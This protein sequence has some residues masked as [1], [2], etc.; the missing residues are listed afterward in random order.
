MYFF[1]PMEYFRGSEF[2]IRLD[3]FWKKFSWSHFG[4]QKFKDGPFEMLIQCTLLLVEQA[5]VVPDMTLGFTVRKHVC[6]RYNHLGFGAHGEGPTKSKIGVISGPTKMDLGPT[7]IKN[8]YYKC[9]TCHNYG[10]PCTYMCYTHVVCR[11]VVVCTYM[12]Y[13]LVVLGCGCVYLHVLYSCGLL[14]C[15][16]LH[17][18]YSCGL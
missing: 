18:L 8:E 12:C 17:V 1:L 5:G 14:G 7:K 3:R 16:Y 4:G 10:K 9:R 13:T 2:T 6:R 11:V 15:V